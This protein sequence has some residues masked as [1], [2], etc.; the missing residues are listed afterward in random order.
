MRAFLDHCAHLDQRRVRRDAHLQHIVS[1]LS[2]LS[3]ARMATA[4]S[5][6]SGW[7]FPPAAGYEN[8]TT[9]GERLIW[10]ERPVTARPRRGWKL[11]RTADKKNSAQ[12]VAADPAVSPLDT[13]AEAGARRPN[14]RRVIEDDKFPHAPRLDPLRA[15]LAKL[16]AAAAPEST[17]HPKAAAKG[18]K[19]ARR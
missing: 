16:E 9:R 14:I 17:A 19:H 1:R 6:A 12:K 15:A 13:P 10:L 2:R 8:E 11:S 4:R 18:D 3:A 7:A 5:R